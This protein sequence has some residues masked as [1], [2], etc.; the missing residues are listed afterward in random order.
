MSPERF[1]HIL[2]LASPLITKQSTSFREAISAGE[3]LALTLRY[4]A[5][6]ESQTSLSFSYRMGKS[7]VSIIQ[8]ETCDAIYQVLSPNYLRPPTTA[9]EWK[10][11]ANMFEEM[12]NLP[13]VVGAMDGKHIRIQCP[14]ET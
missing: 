4:L 10:E 1:D 13:H 7:T 6:M 12:W 11:N 5:S 8:K 14:A 9:I 3:R 2:S